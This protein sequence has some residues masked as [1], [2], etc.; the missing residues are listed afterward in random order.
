[1][2]LGSGWIFMVSKRKHSRWMYMYTEGR[3]ELYKA[4]ARDVMIVPWYDTPGHFVALG[5]GV[6]CS[7]LRVNSSRP[8]SFISPNV[9]ESL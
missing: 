8:Y 3:I 7:S 4:D 5:H 6:V 1:M 9:A 2:H